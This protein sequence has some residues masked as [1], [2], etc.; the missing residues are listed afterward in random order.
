MISLPEC[1]RA[2]SAYVGEFKI[3]REYSFEEA[4]TMKLFFGQHSTLLR[5]CFYATYM[6]K[7]LT[8]LNGPESHCFL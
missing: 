1:T 5:D 8:A 2:G 3:F 4:M 7:T 6:L